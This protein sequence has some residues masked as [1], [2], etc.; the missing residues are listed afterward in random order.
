MRSAPGSLV[1][2]ELVR[3]VPSSHAVLYEIN[4]EHLA[5]PAIALLADL[6]GALIGALHERAPASDGGAAPRYPVPMVASREPSTD[7]LDG[8]VIIRHGER[9]ADVPEP[10]DPADVGT[11]LGDLAGPEGAPAFEPLRIG[12]APRRSDYRR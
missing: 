9:P 7:P 2:S 11:P 1:E 8:L 3:A 5:Y 10:V 4:R 6:R 12:R